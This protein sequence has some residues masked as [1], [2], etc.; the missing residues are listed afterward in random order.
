MKILWI[1]LVF[2]TSTSICS[3]P[4]SILTFTLGFRSPVAPVCPLCLQFLLFFYL[5]SVAVVS[6]YRCGVHEPLW[7]GTA[8]P[9][10]PQLAPHFP[11]DSEVP[12]QV[13]RAQW[14]LHQQWVQL[15][16]E[17]TL[18]SLG[19]AWPSCPFPHSL[20]ELSGM[21]P[22]SPPCSPQVSVLH[23]VRVSDTEHVNHLIV[24]PPFLQSVYHPETRSSIQRSSGK[25]SQW[26]LRH[27]TQ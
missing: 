2:G 4:T 23:E 11:W 10:L 26:Q 12:D 27:W 9:P 13:F 6:R 8:P 3:L 19:K 16:G 18:P 21:P 17:R 22:H 14:A 1:G 24:Q 20:R 25:I 7:A 15:R 5:L